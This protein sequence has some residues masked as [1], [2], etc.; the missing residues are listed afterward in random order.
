MRAL[1]VDDE[2]PA[3]DLLRALLEQIPDVEVVGMAGSVDEADGAIAALQPDVVFLDIQM[4][5]QTGVDL[6][7]SLDGAN[8]AAVIFVTAFDDYALEAFDTAAVDY[9]L[10]PVEPER[11]AISLNR[12]RRV[13]GRPAASVAAGERK[14][15]AAETT[16]A[17][18]VWVQKRHGQL[19]LAV[20]EIDWIE[21]AR[22]YVLLHT[23][24]QS[25]MLRATMETLE[26]TLD[27]EVMMRISR[28]TFVNR[29]SI[30]GF[31]EHGKKNLVVVLE[32]GTGL[33][34]GSTYHRQMWRRLVR[35]GLVERG[36]E[37]GPPEGVEPR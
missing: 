9:L 35:D 8:P 12:A 20:E 24:R 4:P 34:V 33:R 18:G 6:A 28:S 26:R 31:H 1:I 19:R 30:R 23:Q 37:S 22:D 32:D 14:P 15:P 11:L 3:R 29:R 36:E 17:T 13:L 27:P 21:A 5:G 16:W 2:P 25:H 10:K 7:R